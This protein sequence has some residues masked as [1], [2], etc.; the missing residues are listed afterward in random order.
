MQWFS[1]D[2]SMWWSFPSALAQ[3]SDVEL[4]DDRSQNTQASSA[5]RQDK[6]LIYGS[7]VAQTSAW[8]FE[9]SHD[10]LPPRR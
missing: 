1:F 9:R 8:I 10:K 4:S 3:G 5:F 7:P 6:V 2:I